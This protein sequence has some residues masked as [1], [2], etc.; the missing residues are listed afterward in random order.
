MDNEWKARVIDLEMRVAKMERQYATHIKRQG[1]PVYVPKDLKELW[2]AR[3]DMVEEIIFDLV[4]Y[5]PS[6]HRLKSDHWRS[7][8]L[9]DIVRRVDQ[10]PLFD[11]TELAPRS[12]VLALLKT[13]PDIV[14]MT[15]LEALNQRINTTDDLV[16]VKKA[17]ETRRLRKKLK[18]EQALTEI[19]FDHTQ[20]S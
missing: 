6:R 14:L 1:A 10:S 12:I 4:A 7:I 5:R 16:I 15:R 13:I 2:T 8:Y 3:R 9:G 17:K 19:A 18:Y 11:D 20:Q